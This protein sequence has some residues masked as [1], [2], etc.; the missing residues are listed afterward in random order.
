MDETLYE[1]GRWGMAL[2][3]ARG[4]AAWIHAWT[5]VT[6]AQDEDTVCSTRVT[7]G[8]EVVSLPSQVQS[9]MISALAGMVLD[10][11]REEAA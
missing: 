11:L 10:T 6:P 5:Q 4:F 1:Q 8:R 3:M 9:Q 7:A 2:F